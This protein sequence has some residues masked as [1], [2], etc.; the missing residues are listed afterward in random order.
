MMK[1]LF[2]AFLYIIVLLVHGK[3]Y[4]RVDI[5]MYIVVIWA[6]TAVLCYYNVINNPTQWNLMFWPFIYL[7]V[8]FLLFLQPYNSFYINKDSFRG[9]DCHGLRIIAWIYVITGILA[10]YYTLPYAIMNYMMADWDALRND[11]YMDEDSVV[12]YHSAL[13]RLIKNI[14]S[15]IEVF[16]TIYAFYLLTKPKPK[17]NKTLII[18]IFVTWL[19]STLVSSALEASRGMLAKQIMNAGLLYILFKN[20]IPHNTKRL[21]RFSF[22]FFLVLVSGYFISVTVS[23]FGEGD[24]GGDSVLYYLGHSMSTFNDGIAQHIQHYS[25]GKRFFKWFID[26]FGGNS[27]YGN[28]GHQAGTGFITFIG[29][30]YM[31]FGAVGTLI[32]SLIMLPI[33]SAFTRKKYYYFSDLIV[34]VYFAEY[35]LGGVFVYGSGTSLQWFMTFIL[36]FIVKKIE[37]KKIEIKKNSEYARH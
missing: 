34:I 16:A 28:L 5:Y 30:F 25:E 33:I 35:Y 21:L 14:H 12:Y 26:F 15:Y 22:V 17:S 7:F 11:V 4:K 29:S 13:E 9:G 3:K 27:S 10:I 2:N 18:L 6:V 32:L 31:D 23:R 19:I 37:I 36:Y 24:S 1:V 20:E 8:V